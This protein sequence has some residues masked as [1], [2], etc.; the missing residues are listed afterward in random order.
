MEE[1]LVQVAE[2]IANN[3]EAATGIAAGAALFT[4]VG[5]GA[6]MLIEM[7]CL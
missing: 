2:W 1:Y 4:A 5:C 3:P 6:V 7:C